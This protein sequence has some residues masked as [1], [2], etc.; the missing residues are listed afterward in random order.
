MTLGGWKEDGKEG[1]DG[2]EKGDWE[3]KRRRLKVDESSDRGDRPAS[4]TKA[5]MR[6]SSGTEGMLVE[7]KSGVHNQNS[8]LR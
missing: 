8:A 6:E 7:K 1:R 4:R 2:G 5:M 3:G